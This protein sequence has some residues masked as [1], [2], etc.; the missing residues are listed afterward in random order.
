[1]SKDTERPGPGLPR[2]HISPGAREKLTQHHVVH[3]MLM[4]AW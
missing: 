4:A 3:I 2:T 1:M